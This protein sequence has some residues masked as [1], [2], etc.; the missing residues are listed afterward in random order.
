VC[1]LHLLLFLVLFFFFLL[2]LLLHAPPL[3]IATAVFCGGNALIMDRPQLG[4]HW[5]SN[6]PLCFDFIIFVTFILFYYIVSSG[7][8]SLGSQLLFLH[9][10]MYTRTHMHT[11]HT[12]TR[13]HTRTYSLSL[14]LSLSFSLCSLFG[15]IIKKDNPAL[16]ETPADSTVIPQYLRLEVAAGFIVIF[17]LGAYYATADLALSGAT[18]RYEVI[19][20]SLISTSIAS[21]SLPVCIMLV[22]LRPRRKL[23]P[24][25][26][27]LHI[28]SSSFE[29]VLSGA[30]IHPIA[31]RASMRASPARRS[32]MHWMLQAL[33]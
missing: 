3:R 5:C 21:V 13:T 1:F 4:M 20:T 33:V 10:V 28:M 18:N 2:L 22:R 23:D 30:A 12:H 15:P 29:S 6:L 9:S 31:A 27:A 11:H 8:G 16:W 14:S 24:Q 25:R 17:A 26:A 7:L 19:L 32:L